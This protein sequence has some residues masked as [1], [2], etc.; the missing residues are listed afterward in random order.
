[1]SVAVPVLEGTSVA[2]AA[3]PALQRRVRSAIAVTASGANGS[4]ASRLAVDAA[5][6]GES[7][8]RALRQR[9][10]RVSEDLAL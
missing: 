8:T 9:S 2:T 5:T 1:M 10:R 3:D 4:I 7:L 6:D